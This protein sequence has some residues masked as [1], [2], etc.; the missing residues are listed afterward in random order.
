MSPNDGNVDGRVLRVD[1]PTTG[2]SRSLTRSRRRRPHD[3]KGDQAHARP[4]VV[5]AARRRPANAALLLR[6]KAATP[7][8]S[9]APPRRTESARLAIKR[10]SAALAGNR[11]GRAST[12][13]AQLVTRGP[14]QAL[15]CDPHFFSHESASTC[16]DRPGVCESKPGGV[17]ATRDP[18][19]S[20]RTAGADTSCGSRSPF[21]RGQTSSSAL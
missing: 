19:P 2:A 4:R 6:V 12:G 11:C 15:G 16:S 3:R 18:G 1:H 5:L 7:L 8:P 13:C 20:A 14:G 21:G 10:S 17:S 9:V